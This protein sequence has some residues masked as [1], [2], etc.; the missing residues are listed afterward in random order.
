MPP[1]RSQ[2][3]ETYTGLNFVQTDC[4]TELR[5]HSPNRNFID[6]YMPRR[7][8]SRLATYQ[9]TLCIIVCRPY[10]VH[11][12]W[13]VHP[14]TSSSILYFASSVQWVLWEVRPQ[15]IR[16]LEHSNRLSKPQCTDCP[17][18]KCHKGQITLE[19]VKFLTLYQ[20]G[21]VYGT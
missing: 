4:P 15:N 12:C 8:A 20:Y 7:H 9:S 13:T 6:H 18:F 14:V 16:V 5:L 21:G 10:T 17:R 1:W 11:W 19:N 3:S 2:T